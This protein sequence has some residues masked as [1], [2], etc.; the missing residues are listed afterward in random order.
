M[1][2]STMLLVAQPLYFPPRY[3]DPQIHCF[4]RGKAIPVVTAFERDWYGKHLRAAAEPSLYAMAVRGSADSLRFTWLPSFDAPVIVRVE[5]LAGR[6][7][8]L[9]AVRLTGQGGYE[10]G[11]IADRVDR[12]LTSA[13]A[14]DLRRRLIAAN[15]LAITPA[16]CGGGGLDGAQWL[17]ERSIGHRYRLTVRWSPEHGAVR[18]TGMAMLRLTGWRFDAIY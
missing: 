3:V 10:P 9:L 6:A 14:S 1:L 16:E 15:P 2:F 17:V 5:G 18:A 8:R 11:A 7:P 13:E 12:P 4:G